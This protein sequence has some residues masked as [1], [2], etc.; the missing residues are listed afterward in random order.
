MTIEYPTF[1]AVNNLT[2]GQKTAANS[3]P[4]IWASDTGLPTGSNTIGTVLATCQGDTAAAATD[5]GNP[6]KFGGKATTSATA[7]GSGAPGAVTAGQRVNAWLDLNGRQMNG[8]ESEYDTLT[9]INTT[10]NNVTTTATS[11]S[12]TCYQYRQASFS[13]NLAKANS[14]TE[15]QFTFEVSMDGT[16]YHTMQNDYLSALVY[17]STVAGNSPS[18][19]FTFP[20][21]CQLIRVKATSTGTTASATFTVTNAVLYL[22]N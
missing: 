7:S 12:V 17:S 13:L 4:V 14:P 2:L 6:V 10:Y 22:R 1:E 18:H 3:Y 21:G 16:N 11:A 5:A 15:I 8:V 20:I 19:S 9:A